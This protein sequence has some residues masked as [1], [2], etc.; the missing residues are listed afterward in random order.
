MFGW[1]F[2]SFVWILCCYFVL[3]FVEGTHGR[4]SGNWATGIRVLSTD[5]IPCGIGRG[6][7][8]NL[9]KLA[10]GFFIFMVGIMLVALTENWQRV[11]DLAARTVVV[12]AEPIKESCQK[13]KTP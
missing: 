6:L 12:G 4:T 7:L 1:V 8:R 9:L 2:L 3:S 10:D 11:G 13:G 5:L